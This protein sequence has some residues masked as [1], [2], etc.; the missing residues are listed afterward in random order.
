MTRWTGALTWGCRAREIDPLTANEAFEVRSSLFTGIE[1]QGP[2]PQKSHAS[3]INE[4]IAGSSRRDT[5]TNFDVL[6]AAPNA[7]RRPYAYERAEI[8][9]CARAF[10]VL[11]LCAP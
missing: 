5:K 4:L 11:A 2:D 9:A 1:P 8:N 3:I 7:E 10:A 6:T